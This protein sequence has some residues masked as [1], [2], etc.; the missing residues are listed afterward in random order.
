MNVVFLF[1]MTILVLMLFVNAMDP[2]EIE[3]ESEYVEV[4]K[5][6]KNNEVSYDGARHYN[7]SDIHLFYILTPNRADTKQITKRQ[8]NVFKAMTY[9]SSM[10]YFLGIYWKD[11]DVVRLMYDAFKIPTVPMPK[12][13]GFRNRRGKYARWASLIMAASYA[14]QF[15]L[16]NIVILED[17]SAWPKNLGERVTKYVQHGNNSNVV[18]KLSTWGEGF[19]M[20]LPSAINYIKTIYNIGIN[21]SSDVWIRDMLPSFNINKAI[22]YKLLVIPN[23]GNIWNT[24][25]VLNH[26]DFDYTAS[27]YDSSPLTNRLGIC[28]YPNG[29]Y[30]FK[31]VHPSFALFNSRTD[32]NLTKVAERLKIDYPRDLCK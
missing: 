29:S 7:I 15:R 21:S 11:W 23:Q 6:W 19:L 32:L 14:I 26:L 30:E 3:K 18:V 22:K 27:M 8:E 31:D 4:E 10:K 5:I 28:L 17:D 20:S 25:I 12:F 13:R 16:P 9:D 1:V 24:D 2:Q